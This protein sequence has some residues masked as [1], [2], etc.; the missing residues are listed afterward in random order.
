MHILGAGFK[1]ENLLIR[2]LRTYLRE[3]ESIPIHPKDAG[4]SIW[5]TQLDLLLRTF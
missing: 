3:D 2:L 5:D 4:A 1:R